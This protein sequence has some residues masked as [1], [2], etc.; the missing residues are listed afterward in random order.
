[1]KHF[2]QQNAIGTFL[3]IDQVT[4]EGAA[5]SVRERVADIMLG[6]RVLV[7]EAM[8]HADAVRDH[9]DPVALW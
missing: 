4:L 7:D 2:R 8:V 6:D 1:M 3:T 9:R 5:N